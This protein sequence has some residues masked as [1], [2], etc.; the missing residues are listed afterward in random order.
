[1]ILRDFNDFLLVLF[2]IPRL[3][4]VDQNV[5]VLQLQH[6][7][8]AQSPA[9]LSMLTNLALISL[10]QYMHAYSIALSLIANI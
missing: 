5:S 6:M 3:F 10:R 7:N 4:I 2:R 1:M 9:F 8:S